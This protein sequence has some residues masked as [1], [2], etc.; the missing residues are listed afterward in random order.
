YALCDTEGY[1]AGK[2]GRLHRN[3]T[4][5]SWY[6]L[7]P[8]RA[9]AIGA[10][11]KASACHRNSRPHET[12]RRTVPCTG[13]SC[14]GRASPNSDTRGGWR[15][16]NGQPRDR[17]TNYSLHPRVFERRYAGRGRTFVQ[18]VYPHWLRYLR[19]PP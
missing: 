10:T 15:L 16:H 18:L 7:A 12:Q 3:R 14:P 19:P 1:L 6:R 5:N 17:D 2:S 4:Q 9:V 8:Q 13:G 11:T